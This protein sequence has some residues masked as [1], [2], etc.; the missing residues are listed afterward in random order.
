MRAIPGRSTGHA[1]TK[2]LKRVVIETRHQAW[3][4]AVGWGVGSGID[5]GRVITHKGLGRPRA[6]KKGWGKVQNSA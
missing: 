3:D 1:G 4:W 5:L 6:P 2:A